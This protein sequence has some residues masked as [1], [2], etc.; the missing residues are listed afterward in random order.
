MSTHDRGGPRSLFIIKPNKLNQLNQYLGTP[1][2]SL[3]TTGPIDLT[4]YEMPSDIM[5][6]ASHTTMKVLEN[7]ANS[8]MRSTAFWDSIQVLRDQLKL[9]DITLNIQLQGDDYSFERLQSYDSD[10]HSETDLQDQSSEKFINYS[11]QRSRIQVFKY[12]PIF[13]PIE[14]PD[15]PVFR[16]RNQLA[17]NK[18]INFN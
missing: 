13:N 11:A 1:W 18:K 12:L 8:E 17:G 2:S 9:A 10:E 16:K 3:P 15:A 7:N 14:I 4:H 6:V 5:R